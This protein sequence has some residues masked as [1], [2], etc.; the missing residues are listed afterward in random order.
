MGTELLSDLDS[1]FFAD[2]LLTNEDWDACLYKCET[3]EEGED[4][5][6]YLQSFKYDSMFDSDLV[7]SLDPSSPPSPWKQVTEDVL[8]EDSDLLREDN[9]GPSEFLPADMLIQVK[10]EPSSP[11]SCHSSESS[12]SSNCDSSSFYQQSVNCES[13]VTV[14]KSENPPTPPYMF[15]DILSPPLSTVQITISP[16][17]EAQ[18]T[19]ATLKAS[20]ILKSKP[21]IQPKPVCVTTIPVTQ[22]SSPTKTIILQSVQ[23]M[24][25]SIPV[26]GQSM[27]LAQSDLLHLGPVPSMIKVEPSS[28]ASNITAVSGVSG[29]SPATTFTSSNLLSG[30]SKTV[31]SKPIIPAPSHGGVSSGDIDMKVLK[32]QQRMIKN[33]ESACQSRKKKKEYLQSLESKLQEALCENEKLRKENASLR[34]LLESVNEGTDVRLGF[35]NNRKAV[36]V[37]VFLLFITFSFGPVRITD[38]TLEPTAPVGT[39]PLKGR[40]LLGFYPDQEAHFNNNLDRE[41]EAEPISMK[42]R[43]ETEMDMK[44]SSRRSVHFRN[45]TATFSDV[46]DLMLRDMHQ[47]F[48]T[49]DCRQF[50]R[51][52]SLRLADELHGWV[53]RHQID[54]KKL[55]EKPQRAKKARMAQKAQQRKFNLSRY[56][57][58]HSQ[59]TVDRVSSSQLQIYPGPDQRNDDFLDAIDRREDTFYVVSF[60]RDHLLLPAIS[61]NKTSRP[62]MSLVMPA[63]ALNETVYNS[64]QGYEVMMQIDCE[65]M[66]TRIIQIK[67]SKVPAFLKEHRRVDNITSSLHDRHSAPSAESTRQD[68]VGKDRVGPHAETSYL[69]SQ[70]DAV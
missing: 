62:K 21:A 4:E 34:K 3:M 29:S 56:L 9:A 45:V 52:E 20:S 53:Y 64:S 6:D 32:R 35:A 7:L 40:R 59:K 12:M 24:D 26:A 54:R 65:V 28:P 70:H 14:L 33:R 22:T 42:M 37:M 50:N 47:L 31:N 41:K 48:S 55:G 67:S 17:L 11:A 66:D 10:S 1:R 2:N 23:A 43:R 15:G 51:T 61:H 27:M 44:A 60:R 5:V 18:Q 63:M 8:T 25:Q 38:K 68:A 69:L 58:A 39:G 16:K 30:P 49:S 13:P 19:T 57:P 46:K 36:C